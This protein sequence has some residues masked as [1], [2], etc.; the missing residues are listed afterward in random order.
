[1]GKIV[2]TPVQSP[3]FIRPEEFGGNLPHFSQ[4][5]QAGR[6]VEEAEMNLGRKDGPHQR[7][8]EKPSPPGESSWRGE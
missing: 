4:I 1:V 8:R 7:K 2:P 6:E 3:I 5:G